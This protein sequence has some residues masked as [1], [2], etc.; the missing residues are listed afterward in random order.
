MFKPTHPLLDLAVRLRTARADAGLSQVVAAA[1]SGVSLGT[2]QRAEAFGAA[3]TRTLLAMARTYGVPID[4]LRGR[5]G[6]P[7]DLSTEGAK[8]PR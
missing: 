3:S 6:A 1:R 8:V 2:L 5:A 4:R 7:G